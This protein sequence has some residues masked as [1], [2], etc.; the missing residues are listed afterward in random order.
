[1][2]RAEKYGS[3]RVR[4]QV[5]RGEG[6]KGK[7]QWSNGAGRQ[8]SVTSVSTRKGGVVCEFGVDGGQYKRRGRVEGARSIGFSTRECHPIYGNLESR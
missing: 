6:R 2:T 4:G 8:H 3:E 7:E 5:R 1:M